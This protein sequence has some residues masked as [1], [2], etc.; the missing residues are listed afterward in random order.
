MYPE[1]KDWWIQHGTYAVPP[2]NLPSTGAVAVDVKD[3]DT[4]EL[5]AAAWVYLDSSIPFSV[6]A[7]PVV[8]PYA[9]AKKKADA[10]TYVARHLCDFTKDDLQYQVMLTF[11]S[12]PSV[13]RILEDQGFFQIDTNITALAKGL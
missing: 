7:W 10:L 11:S 3:D 5:I 4:E 13:T 12:V 6:F 8:N 1:I 2:T 9:T